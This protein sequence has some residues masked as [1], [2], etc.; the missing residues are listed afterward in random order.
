MRKLWLLLT[1]L[2]FLLSGCAPST[3]IVNNGIRA[4]YF[5]SESKGAYKM[6]CESGDFKK[7]L[8][9]AELHEE[10]KEDFYEY[11]C[12]E[13]R[14]NQKVISLYTFLTPEEK[15]SLKRVFVRHNYTINSVPC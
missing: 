3:F 12:T 13:H 7:V 10:I 11:V 1:V 6:L 15:K 5:G 4:Y 14:S 9:D 8:R 2:V